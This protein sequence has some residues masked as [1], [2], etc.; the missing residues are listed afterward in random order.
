LYLHT[1]VLC[2]C[3][4]QTK[5]SLFVSFTKSENRRAEQVLP[6]SSGRGGGGERV[7]G[8]VCYR[9]CI[10]MCGNGKIPGMGGVG[11]KENGRG[12]EFKCD[13]WYIVRTFINVTLYN[14]AQQ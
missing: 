1:C 5:M 2:C 8:W 6:G 12:G 3:L 14:P 9:C 7:G 13:I 10:H 11:M 4:K